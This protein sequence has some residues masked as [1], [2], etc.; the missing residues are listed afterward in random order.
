MYAT[1]KCMD[2]MDMSL[3]CLNCRDLALG[4][5]KYCLVCMWT[6]FITMRRHIYPVS[7]KDIED[8]WKSLI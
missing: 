1:Y 2:N 5:S 4:V 6:N 3:P 8:K 7:I